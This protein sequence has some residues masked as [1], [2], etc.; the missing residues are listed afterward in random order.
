MATEKITTLHPKN[1]TSTNLYPNVKSENIIDKDTTSFTEGHVPDSKLVQSSLDDLAERESNRMDSIQSGV[2][3]NSASITTLTTDLANETSA[4]EKADSSI[5]EDLTTLNSSLLS[6]NSRVNDLENESVYKDNDNTLTGDNVFEG[7]NTFTGDNKFNQITLKF[8][9]YINIFE[10]TSYGFKAYKDSTYFNVQY[11]D[12][13]LTLSVNN[14]TYYFPAN[15]KG[16]IVLIEDINMPLR[17]EDMSQLD[18]VSNNT[19]TLT[20]D[21]SSQILMF[22]LAYAMTDGNI[23]TSYVILPYTSLVKKSSTAFICKYGTTS[24]DVATCSASL[25]NGVITI[26]LD[27][28]QGT[29]YQAYIVPIFITSLG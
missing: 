20:I 11:N 17:V 19:F 18:R 23:Y 1:D 28:I 6:T 27:N 26:D 2:N 13:Q 7:N 12:T 22:I 15:K 3:K 24:D 8:G 21:T 16:T 25:V 14:S 10:S 9:N 5:Q 4:R 29:V